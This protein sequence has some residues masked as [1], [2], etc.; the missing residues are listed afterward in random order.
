MSTT[1]N[2]LSNP[3]PHNRPL[4]PRGCESWSADPAINR[5]RL[6]QPVSGQTDSPKRVSHLLRTALH[7]FTASFEEPINLGCDFFDE[8]LVF[9][10][11]A[12]CER[13][14]GNERF[15][16][17]GAIG[18]LLLILRLEQCNKF[19]LELRCVHEATSEGICYGMGLR[20]QPTR[21]ERQAAY[22]L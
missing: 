2:A 9:T 19:R 18:Y 22:L 8:D 15:D 10:L 3:P 11:M 14:A 6:A 17:I 4:R 5:S 12:K 7:G 13:G 21:I 20:R 1:G 16:P